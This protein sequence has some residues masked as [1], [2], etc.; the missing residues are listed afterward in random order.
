MLLER[1]HAAQ[2]ALEQEMGKAPL[3]RF[4]HMG[5]GR[6]YDVSKMRKNRSGKVG[7]PRDVSVARSSRV[8]MA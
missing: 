2:D 7:R 1:G 3:H 6:M 8:P 4:F 5:T